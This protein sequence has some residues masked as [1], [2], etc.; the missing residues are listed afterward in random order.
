[1]WSMHMHPSLSAPEEG[2]NVG[3]DS[4]SGLGQLI[5]TPTYNS[6]LL[7]G[8]GED[9]DADDQD[10]L[11]IIEPQSGSIYV[12]QHPSSRMSS[13]SRKQQP[14]RKLPYTLPQLVDR[15]PFFPASSQSDSRESG[16]MFVGRKETRLLVLELETGKVRGLVDPDVCTWDQLYPDK[17][18][19]DDQDDTNPHTRKKTEIYISRT[20]YR[21]QIHT[22]PSSPS[23][24]G[25]RKKKARTQTLLYSEYG[26]N[27]V[28]SAMQQRYTTTR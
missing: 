28:H 14:L 24:P 11:Y 23:T 22:R 25:S 17:S 2:A 21:L 15:S 27:M 18:E 12:L 9:D 7:L 1:M 26:P 8:S 16:K 19:A 5:K 3:N 6:S 10:D 4:E 20:D 13:S